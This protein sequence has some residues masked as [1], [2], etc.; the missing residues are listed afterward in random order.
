MKK[1]IIFILY[2]IVPFISAAQLDSTLL[3]SKYGINVALI[4]AGYKIDSV[5]VSEDSS[6]KIYLSEIKIFADSTIKRETKYTISKDASD[7]DL[8]I[9]GLLIDETMTKGGRDFYEYF[10]KDWTA[11]YGIKN[12]MIFILERPY[13][14]NNTLIEIKINETLVFQSFLQRRVE[15]IEELAHNAAKQV[16]QYLYQYDELMKQLGGADMNGNG[17]Y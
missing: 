13:R 5:I 8:E 2:I 6:K 7:V 10:Y 9:D 4:P 17:M 14:L 12:Y 16:K 11:P 15:A 1:I 3:I